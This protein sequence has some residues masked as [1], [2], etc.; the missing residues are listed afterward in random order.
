MPTNLS[1]IRDITTKWMTLYLLC[2]FPCVITVI[3][4]FHLGKQFKIRIPT[5]T[6]HREE[7][8]YLIRQKNATM[9][10]DNNAYT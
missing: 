1:R 7:N 3:E 8:D 6:F 10:I 9:D 4:T 5:L 2:C